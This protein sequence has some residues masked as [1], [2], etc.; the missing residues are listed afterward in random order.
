[1]WKSCPYCREY[2]FDEEALVGL[3]VDFTP[4]ACKQC[5]KLVRNDSLRQLLIIPAMLTGALIGAL[6]LYVFPSWLTPVAWVLLG[7][8]VIIPLILLPKPVKADQP[9]LSLTPFDPDANNDKVIFVSGWNEDELRTILDGYI[10][11]G[12]PGAP[13]YGIVFHQEQE[14]RYWL[15]FPQDTHP[16]VF[17]SLVNYLLYPIE[18]GIGDRT[19]T[20]VGKTTLNSAFEGIPESLC[21]HKALLY[22]PEDDQDHDVV[23]LQTDGGVNLA[24]S[25]SENEGWKSVKTARLSPDVKR[26]AET[27][28][29]HMN[30]DGPHY[31]PPSVQ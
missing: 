24:Y 13:S 26:L 25:F 14:D 2:S 27:I 1:M 11:E 23:Y 10:A 5:G 18:F 8:L 15:T 17:A 22:V 30:A 3:F 9:E 6:A 21:G 28:Q 4:R 20:V 31:Q 19:I 7:I 16:F 12:P 29:P